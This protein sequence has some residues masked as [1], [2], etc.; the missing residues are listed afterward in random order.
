MFAMT[1][2]LGG[3]HKQVVRLVLLH[4]LLNI[5]LCNISR[6]KGVLTDTGVSANQADKVLLLI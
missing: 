4:Y 1:N 6:Y 2:E 3:V 5:L